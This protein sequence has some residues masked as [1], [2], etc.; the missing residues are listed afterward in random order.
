[1]HIFV[2]PMRR[3]HAAHARDLD[4]TH[5]TAAAAAAG[6]HDARGNENE[7]AASAHDFHVS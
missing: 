2:P 1:M 7:H 4:T 3:I 5:A 6:A